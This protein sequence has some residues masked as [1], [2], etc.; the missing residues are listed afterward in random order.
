M[1]IRKEF[2]YEMG[3]IVR[4]AWSRRCSKNAHGHSYRVEFFFEGADADNGQMLQDFGFIKQYIHPF[5]DA[6]DHS[7]WI[8]NREED[9]HIT[10]FFTENFE[11]VILTPF[12]TTAE[13]QAKLFYTYADLLMRYLQNKNL[14]E[15]GEVP[16]IR[17]SRV[18]VHETT[19]GY[20][21]YRPEGDNFPMTRITD[22][23]FSEQIMK[24]WG[25][26]YRTFYNELREFK[27]PRSNIYK[28]NVD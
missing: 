11:R 13:M 15:N 1:E 5:V 27:Q 16:P 17:C 21:E 4:N 22:I 24:E 25:D 18:I 9:Q 19:T 20:A 26:T 12:S 6:F 28:L 23:T 8:W 3:H 7:F 14:F 10:K 2:K